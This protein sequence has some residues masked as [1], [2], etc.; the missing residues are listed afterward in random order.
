VRIG[1]FVGGEKKYFL[2]SGQGP[3]PARKRSCFFKALRG[4]F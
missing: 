3:P 2:A 4:A 1:E